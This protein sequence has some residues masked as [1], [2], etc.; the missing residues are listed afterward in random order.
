MLIPLYAQ[1]N[2]RTGRIQEP[3]RLAL[4]W[5][6]E[7][8]REQVCQMRPW[9]IARSE[10]VHMLCDARSTPP[11]V[12][13]VL[14]IGKQILYSDAEPPQEI[15][16]AFASRGDNQ[17]TSL[18]ILAIAFGEHYVGERGLQ[19]VVLFLCQVCPLSL[20]RSGAA[21]CSSTVTT[22]APSMERTRVGPRPSTIHA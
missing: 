2:T 11:R 8:L 7:V 22:L 10:T 4:R 20:T 12:A 5:W 14:V 15:M 3:L 19:C 17:I 1:K 6:C 16:G 18:E 9:S 21:T 13:A